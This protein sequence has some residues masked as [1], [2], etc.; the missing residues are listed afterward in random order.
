[1]SYMR[2]YYRLLRHESQIY[3]LHE[4]Y[5]LWTAMDVTELTESMDFKALQ[6]R[7]AGSQS[8]LKHRIHPIMLV[9]VPYIEQERLIFSNPSSNAYLPPMR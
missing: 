5:L 4:S 2:S 3:Y 7:P 6:Q 1:M 8:S 9:S